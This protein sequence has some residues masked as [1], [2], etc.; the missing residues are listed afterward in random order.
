MALWRLLAYYPDGVTCAFRDWYAVQDEDI[1]AEFDATMDILLDYRD[2]EDDHYE[3]KALV[4]QHVGL[5]EIRFKTT[6]QE[7]R[8]E[9]KFRPLGIWPP[10]ERRVF[11]LLVGCEKPRRGIYIPPDPFATAL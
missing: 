5:G 4:R 10:L 3:F 2:W 7:T 6:D 8:R 9:R 11:V 1:Q